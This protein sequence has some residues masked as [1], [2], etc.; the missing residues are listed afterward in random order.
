MDFFEAQDRARRSSQL[1]TLLFVLAVVAV[2][3]LTTL[4]LALA[5]MITEHG[6]WL[7]SSIRHPPSNT[8]WH[9]PQFYLLTAGVMAVII[10]GGSLYKW[11]SLQAGGSEV[12]RQLGGVLVHPNTTDP[13]ERRLLNVV[14][15]MSIAA[16]IPPPT[17]YVLDHEEGINA[18]AAGLS[19]AVATIGITRGAL[20]ALTR[21]ELQG[22]IAHEF[23]HI[24]NGD[25]R[26]NLKLVAFLHGLLIIALIGSSCLRLA[27]DS[28]R[29]V[30]FRA[31]GRSSKDKGVLPLL[32]VGVTLW[33]IG[34]AGVLCGRLLKAA[35]S[36]EREFLADAAAVEFTR[37]PSG[38]AGA[39]QKVALSGA[40]KALA[41]PQ[42]E[43]FTHMLFSGASVRWLTRLFSTHPPLTERLKRLLP[44]EVLTPTSRP[45]VNPSGDLHE[46][47]DDSVPVQGFSHFGPPNTPTT[48]LSVQNTPEEGIG[49]LPLA[50]VQAIRHVPQATEVVF[51]LITGN[52]ASGQ[53]VLASRIEGPGANNPES[54]V[55]EWS[56]QRT[57]T[58]PQPIHQ[59]FEAKLNLILRTIP[60]LRELHGPQRR[61]LITILREAVEADQQLSIFELGIFT[62]LGESLGVSTSSGEEIDNTTAA[63]LILGCLAL[64]G[65]A[66]RDGAA[67]AFTAAW[68]TLHQHAAN[69][70][71]APRNL[72]EVSALTFGR[73][74]SSLGCLSQMESAER[75]SLMHAARSLINS[76]S[77]IKAREY[78]FFRILGALLD[79]PISAFPYLKMNESAGD[80]ISR[81]EPL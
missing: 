23:S 48:A 8:F 40:N 81:D 59:S 37:N 28:S 71:P 13:E 11:I 60:T 3:A 66:S 19:P 1:L 9:Q 45:I 50:L 38:I 76:D 32:L 73:L 64:L 78:Q 70:A 68:S 35:I 29:R 44:G 5:L 63:E 7:S 58:I 34:Y 47:H 69:F 80:Q 24:L 42:V 30:R 77:H 36:R 61:A 25:M 67:R 39:L 53:P 14:E 6:A 10:L 4:G 16:G 54:A 17:L 18:F 21:D 20:R 26:L 49:T 2:V 12:A 41:H 75:A 72:P 62:L 15:E 55:R 46:A 51:Q 74:S 22:V 43:E 27:S 79:I 57:V 31:Q 52:A 56:V 33:L 65:E